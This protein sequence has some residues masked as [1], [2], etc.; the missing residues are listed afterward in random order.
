MYVNYMSKNVDITIKIST[1]GL[2]QLTRELVNRKR[3]LKKSPRVQHIER[4]RKHSRRENERYPR[5]RMKRMGERQFQEIMGDNFPKVKK[6]M[7]PQL[8]K[9]KKHT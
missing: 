9:L 8:Q 6:G 2:D 4:D 7:G 1:A 5:G 3:I